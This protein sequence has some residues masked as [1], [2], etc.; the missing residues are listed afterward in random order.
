MEKLLEIARDQSIETLIKENDIFS[1]LNNYPH[2]N[3]I[4]RLFLCQTPQDMMLGLEYFD[5]LT[6]ADHIV[7]TKY[8]R[9]RMP[10][11]SLHPVHIVTV[12]KQ[13][14]EAIQHLQICNVFH[15]D[16][17]P[18]NVLYNE[19]RRQSKLID[20]GM[21]VFGNRANEIFKSQGGTTEFMAPET[22]LDGELMVGTDLFGLGAA[23]HHVMTLELPWHSLENIQALNAEPLD[24]NSPNIANLKAQRRSKRRHFIKAEISRYRRLLPPE[25]EEIEDIEND[26]P[27]FLVIQEELMCTESYEFP[28]K[29]IICKMLRHN[30]R[31]RPEC[32]DILKYI[33]DNYTGA[34]AIEH[35]ISEMSMSSQSSRGT[36]AGDN[37]IANEANEEQEEMMS[38]QSANN[39]PIFLTGSS[40]QEMHTNSASDRPSALQP[41]FSMLNKNSSYIDQPS[42]ARQQLAYPSTE[43][44]SITQSGM[45]PTDSAYDD[46]T[47][48]SA[49]VAGN[50]ADESSSH[51]SMPHSDNFSMPH[52]DNF[53]MPHSDNFSM[54]CVVG[55]GASGSTPS[56]LNGLRPAGA[57]PQI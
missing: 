50:Q 36:L 40:I 31:L 32:E 44:M 11:Y 17:K 55:D 5:G 3:I 34:P 14:T 35:Q 13:Q 2:V 28:L 20:F 27:R 19:K 22:L 10:T 53:S 47:G 48:M 41:N 23:L 56:S 25:E 1:Y 49:Y 33:E 12:L 8:Y 46:P 51:F 21:A 43:M 30:P 7:L 45:E 37:S 6:L 54:P 15:C 52:S 42:D 39:I 38:A 26:E 16:F 24:H 4:N 9:Q 29:D 57:G 18:E